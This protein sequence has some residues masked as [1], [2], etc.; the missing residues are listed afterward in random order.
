MLGDGL[1]FAILHDLSRLL[2]RPDAVARPA[3][4]L[5]SELAEPE[6]Q[7]FLAVAEMHRV[8]V[9]SLR[10]LRRQAKISSTEL[11]EWV[12]LVLRDEEAE[13]QKS[14]AMFAA[15][16]GMLCAAGFPAVVIKSLDHWPDLGSDFDIYTAGPADDLRSLMQKNFDA[17]VQ[18]QSWSDRLAGK[19]RFEIRG[20]NR[21]IEIHLG[22]LGQTGQQAHMGRST[23]RRRIT[24]AFDD[25][26]FSV[27]S[28]EDQILIRSIDRC[29]RHYSLRI[30]DIVDIVEVIRTHSIDFDFLK[31]ESKRAGIRKGVCSYLS[32]VDGYYS[33]YGDEHL[34]LPSWVRKGAAFSVDKIYG[35]AGL[36]RIPIFPQGADLFRHELTKAIRRKDVKK[37][38]RTSLIPPLAVA[39]GA[40]FR[41]RGRD[42]GI[43]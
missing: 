24:R 5:L 13:A 4:E 43:W 16:C 21:L 11:P 34:F 17:R 3:I 37:A 7:E 1:E 40:Q 33:R 8:L 12:L 26:K 32:I 39:A 2:L 14:V 6:Q 35:H 28:P 20:L 15:V 27:P 31:R 9:R 25:Y 29:Y 23:L 18:T 22:G 30:C 42:K 36:F 10:A 41:I 19:W 38:V